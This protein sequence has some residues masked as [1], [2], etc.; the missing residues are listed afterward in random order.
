M[1][2]DIRE[3]IKKEKVVFPHLLDTVRTASIVDLNGDGSCSFYGLIYSSYLNKLEGKAQ[4][5]LSARSP[6][7]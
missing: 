5:L 2:Q 6:S 1:P 4:E 7:L 3:V